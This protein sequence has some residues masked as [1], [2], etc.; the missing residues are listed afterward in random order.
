MSSGVVFSADV[1]QA[2]LDHLPHVV[3]SDVFGSTESM[4]LGRNVT[5]K[6]VMS[7]TATFKAKAD[8]RVISEDGKDVIPGSGQSGMLAIV[9][10]QALGYYGDP[11]KTASVFRILDGQRFV[12]PGDWA[13][14]DVD[15]T[16]QLLGRG[17]GCIN[18]GGEKVFPEE[19]EIE[20]KGHTAVYDAVVL[21]IPDIRFGQSVVAIIELRKNQI[22]NPEELIAFVKSRLSSYKA[23]RHIL[24]API[25]RGPNAK[26]DL[27]SLQ[28]FANEQV[29][30]HLKENA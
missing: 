22:A 3:I 25:K 26:P 29:A 18:T 8:T 30:Q 14:V 21:G 15:G 24:F 13:T 23:P 10:R 11:V 9:G 1:K 12:V 28:A 5:S 19:V 7:A 20:L 27:P 17:S 16:V 2:I 4:S 6:G